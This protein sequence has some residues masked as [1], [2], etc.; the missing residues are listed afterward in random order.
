MAVDFGRKSVAK[1][2]SSLRRQRRQ[3]GKKAK[4]EGEE[5]VGRREPVLIGHFLF[6]FCVIGP[7]P[8][9]LVPHTQGGP[10][11]FTLSSLDS[12]NRCGQRCALSTSEGLLG[13]AKF[14]VKIKHPRYIKYWLMVI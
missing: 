12:P 7:Q 6:C 9:P 8:T 11:P 5:E 14:T 1:D 2:S 3:K 13:T 4:K 10:S